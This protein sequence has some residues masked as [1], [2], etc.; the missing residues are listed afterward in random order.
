MSWRRISWSFHSILCVDSSSA[1]KRDSPMRAQRSSN[2]AESVSLGP[3]SLIL[4]LETLL[5]WKSAP[6]S[7]RRRGTSA[8]EWPR[9]FK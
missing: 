3:F 6:E 4:S 9:K 2:C 8:L 7:V 1:Q 5:C